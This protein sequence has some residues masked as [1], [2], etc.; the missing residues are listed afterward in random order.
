V[1][2]NDQVI[3]AQ[4]KSP[5]EELV[6]I[7]VIRGSIFYPM[8]QLNFVPSPDVASILHALLDA[9]ERRPAESRERE[10]GHGTRAIRFPMTGAPLP[11]YHSQIDPIPRQTA[12]EQFRTLER[13]GLVKLDWLPGETG[14]L[15]ASVTLVVEQAGALFDWLDRTPQAVHRARLIELLLGERFRFDGW[16]LTAIQHCL[17]QNR[18]ISLTLQPDRCR[19]QPRC[20]D[21]AGCAGCRARGNAVPRVQRARLQR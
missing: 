2:A 16:R 7:R 18:K 3:R 13:L 8:E 6:C 1:E 12:N 15:L 5:Q 10:G 20:A 4:R 19:I 21:R 9:Y 11:S 17:D 14:H